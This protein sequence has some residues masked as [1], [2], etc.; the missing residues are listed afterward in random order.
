MENLLVIVIFR[1][2]IRTI[3]LYTRY[4]FFW[5]IGK[6][7]SL[8]SLSYES[9]DMYK[10]LGKEITQDFLNAVIGAIVFVLIVVSI[11]FS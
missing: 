7:K 6:K 9:K 1:T 4:C 8:K 10:D 2:I 3:G 11:V 5:A